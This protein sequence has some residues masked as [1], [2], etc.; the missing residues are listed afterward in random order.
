[1]APLVMSS[2]AL[3]NEGWE[4]VVAPPTRGTPAA[5]QALTISSAS[6]RVK[7]MGLSTKMP[8]MPASTAFTVRNDRPFVFVAMARM[9]RF[10]L[11]Y[12]SKASVYRALMP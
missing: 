6:F 5:A 7:T 3:A 12:I 4:V 8:L 2:L 9:S 11:R 1:M 10:S